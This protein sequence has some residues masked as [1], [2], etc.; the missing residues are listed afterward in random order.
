MMLLIYK[1]MQ[2]LRD[3]RGNDKKINHEHMVKVIVGLKIN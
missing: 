1:Q 3:T 2:F